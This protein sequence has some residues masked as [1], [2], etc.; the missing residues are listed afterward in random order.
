MK[1]AC[2]GRE[3]Q[4]ERDRERES[5]SGTSISTLLLLARIHQVQ[6][7][8]SMDFRQLHIIQWIG[9]RENLQETMVFSVIYGG[10][11][12]KFP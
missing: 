4:R 3:R 12:I 11:P 6:D 2:G 1:T 5:H 10:F 7:D 8:F 9:L